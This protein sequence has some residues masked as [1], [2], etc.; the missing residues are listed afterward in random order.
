MSRPAS[1]A[2]GIATVVPGMALL[3]LVAFVLLHDRP[4]T[5]ISGDVAA[6]LVLFW[7]AALVLAG[8]LVVV[9]VVLAATNDRLGGA[10]KAVWVL[11][12]VLAL[13]VAAPGYW[14]A[15]LRPAR[16]TSPIRR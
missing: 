3:L 7:V 5:E 8:V 10:G 15:F 4:W 16:S 12:I 6:M 2:L 14:W 11:L 13:P 9:Y 1:T